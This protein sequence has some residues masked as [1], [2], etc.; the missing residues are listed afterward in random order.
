MKKEFNLEMLSR[1]KK[2][3]KISIENAFGKNYIPYVMVQVGTTQALLQNKDLKMFLKNLQK[4]MHLIKT[5]L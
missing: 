5:H 3:A 1:S 4:A 2:V